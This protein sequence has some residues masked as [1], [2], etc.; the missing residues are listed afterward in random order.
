MNACI[1]SAGPNASIVTPPAPANLTAQML[2]RDTIGYSDEFANNTTA[3]TGNID[4]NNPND[5]NGAIKFGIAATNL[6]T[7]TVSDTLDLL[8]ETAGGCF[9]SAPYPFGSSLLVPATTPE[10]IFTCSGIIAFRCAVATTTTVPNAINATRFISVL[11][12]KGRSHT[13][14]FAARSS[15][16]APVRMF[17]IA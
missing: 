1:A 7:A 12:L 8:C 2:F 13:Y 15:A 14:F 16:R 17:F 11:S 6:G 4:F 10:S 3:Q 5:A 9:W